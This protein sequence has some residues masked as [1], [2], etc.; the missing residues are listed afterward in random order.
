MRFVLL[1]A[2][3]L[4]PMVVVAYV[5][6]RDG[7]GAAPGLVWEGFLLGGCAGLVALGVQQLLSH[8]GGGGSALTTALVDSFLRAGLLEEA[9]KLAAVMVFTRDHADRQ[10][11]HDLLVAAAAVGGGFAAIENIGFLL[12]QRQWAAIA[13]ARA[14]FS[15]PGHVFA[16]A[17]GGACLA[18]AELGGGRVR[19]WALALLLP[20]TL[21]GLYDFPLIWGRGLAAPAGG[22]DMLPL[23]A[24]GVVVVIGAK[25]SSRASSRIRDR[26]AESGWGAAGAPSLVPW[27]GRAWRVVG[28]TLLV[29]GIGLMSAPLFQAER[30]LAAMGL[31]CLFYA[32][33]CFSRGRAPSVG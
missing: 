32:W 11:P 21:H 13:I 9:A 14:L 18:F 25:F 6:S 20:A 3:V 2:A 22:A 10:C 5:R 16:A 12:D 17:L 19:Y 29:G 33:A 30:G 15:A 28:I 7:N 27:H 4:P 8:L 23:F 24:S 26:Q 1:L 31:P